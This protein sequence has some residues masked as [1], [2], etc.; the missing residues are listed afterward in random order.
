MNIF[1][2]YARFDAATLNNG[3]CVY[4]LREERPFLALGFVIHS[5]AYADPS[6]KH[7]LAHFVE[8]LVSKNASVTQDAL[9]AFFAEL[10][11]SIILGSTGF[12]ATEYHCFVLNDLSVVTQALRLW[13]SMLL[14]AHLTNDVALEKETVLN[15]FKHRFPIQV[16]YDIKLRER[17]QVFHGEWLA[18]R[19]RPLGNLESITT[20]TQ[21]D[22]QSF[23]DT[24]YV[25]CNISIVCVGGVT[26]KELL[27]A[28]EQAGFGDSGFSGARMAL[29]APIETTPP[30]EP[31]YQWNYSD[32][33]SGSE[34]HSGIYRSVSRLPA[35]TPRATLALFKR[36]L[37]KLLDKRVREECGHT[38][39]ISSAWERW[40]SSMELSI[41]CPRLHP[42]ALDSIDELVQQAI[43]DVLSDKAGF[44]EQRRWMLASLRYEDANTQQMRNSAMSDLKRFHR[45]APTA[46][47]FGDVEAAVFADM[48][49]L[50]S[51]LTR[52]NRWVMEVR[53]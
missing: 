39:H 14:G 37:S 32:V 18:S 48:S 20:F 51:L 17:S 53:P 28:L 9:R 13:R 33:I 12:F 46:E 30:L 21:E 24:H 8:H 10:G 31:L 5:G 19:V 16:D 35:A 11:G 29:P 42:D 3:L 38:Y 50:E 47:F 44:E 40:F 43:F 45:I 25:P 52:S 34:I 27:A 49:A 7:G 41:D 22:A 2:P 6:G 15:E 1:D 23:Y 36:L 26:F 4:H